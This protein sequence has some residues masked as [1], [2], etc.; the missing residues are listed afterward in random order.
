MPWW[1]A[2]R[3]FSDYGTSPQSKAVGCAD[4]FDEWHLD[5]KEIRHNGEHGQAPAFARLT[6]LSAIRRYDRCELVE[7]HFGRRSSRPTCGK[8]ERVPGQAAR[9]R[10]SGRGRYATPPAP[11]RDQLTLQLQRPNLVEIGLIRSLVTNEPWLPSTFITTS[12]PRVPAS[13]PEGTEQHPRDHRRWGQST[14]AL[15]R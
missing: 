12:I 14:I 1:V 8:G 7:L 13:Y 10:R 2:S 9:V 6:H 15:S 5:L 4:R 11:V 3:K